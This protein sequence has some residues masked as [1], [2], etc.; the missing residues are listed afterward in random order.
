VGFSHGWVDVALYALRYWRV[1]KLV[2]DNPVNFWNV[3]NSI[4]VLKA[5]QTALHE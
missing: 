2:V 1:T 5:I 3:G 4:A